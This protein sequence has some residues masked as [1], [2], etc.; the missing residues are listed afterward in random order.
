MLRGGEHAFR[1]IP[2]AE[3]YSGIYTNA[4]YVGSAICVAAPGSL[5]LAK[6]PEVPASSH[7]RGAAER[8]GT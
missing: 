2:R 7:M 5:F 6:R 1:R 4:F 8:K 3:R